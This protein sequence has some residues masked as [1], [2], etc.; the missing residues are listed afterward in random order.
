MKNNNKG[1]IQIPILIAIILGTLLIGGASYV[2][3]QKMTSQKETPKNNELQ[4]VEEIETL[5]KELDD[6]KSKQAEQQNTDEK[7]P[8]IIE[9]I[10]ERP[11]VVEQSQNIPVSNQNITSTKEVEKQTFNIFWQNSEKA[12]GELSQAIKYNT[13]AINSNSISYAQNAI[14]SCNSG[15]QI[16]LNNNI[17][18]LPFSADLTAM[19]KIIAT[20]GVKCK[21]MAQTAQD[22]FKKFAEA[23]SENYSLTARMDFTAQA[24]VLI[25]ESSDFYK[26]YSDIWSNQLIPAATKAQESAQEYFK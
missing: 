7:E 25:L 15:Y 8:K 24:Q 2:G 5:K 11:V 12:W 9:R 19:N 18:N 6:L 23:Q 1:F 21:Q 22:S 16:N 20:L 17:P 14:D 13:D 4:G 3:V 10:I 26:E